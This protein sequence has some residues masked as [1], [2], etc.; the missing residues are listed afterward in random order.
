[1]LCY[2]CKTDK[3]NQSFTP[4]QFNIT[5]PVCRECRR[6]NNQTQ[7][8]EEKRENKL[9]KL[10]HQKTN[11]KDITVSIHSDIK[12]Y[13]ELNDPDI[14]FCSQYINTDKINIDISVPTAI[15]SVMGTGKTKYVQKIIELARKEEKTVCY[16]CPNISTIQDTRQQLRDNG[17]T[18]SGYK[19]CNITDVVLTTVDSID[20]FLDKDI[21]IIDEVYS[22]F[23]ELGLKSGIQKTGILSSG[24]ETRYRK[25]LE[26]RNVFIL[27]RFI[28]PVLR[29][30]DC[31]QLNGDSTKMRDH[32]VIHNTYK[33]TKQILIND[34]KTDK[35]VSEVAL[36]QNNNLLVQSSE[37][38]TIDTF[39]KKLNA[40]GIDNIIKTS[41]TNKELSNFDFNKHQLKL[42]SPV[43]CRGVS[44][45]SNKVWII[46]SG[47]TVGVVGMVQM[48]DRSRDSKVINIK[49]SNG[50]KQENALLDEYSKLV[51]CAVTNRMIKFISF[52]NFIEKN[53]KNV[54]LFLL[55][56]TYNLL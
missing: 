38:R 50:S 17:I 22:V 10:H 47:R 8:P 13:F 53:H 14:T 30:F 51:E 20:K 2:K 11:L 3:D 12:K 26:H 49:V 21:L 6:K 37:K 35:M 52:N 40:R 29:M 41:V 34:F 32:Q 5:N 1:M 18:V 45:N 36:E 15:Q 33:K 7:T 46:D 43:I 27:D 48:T 42:A 24:I 56:E 44:L 25:I 28:G 54:Y 23:E 31:F 55:Q 39:S 4:S 19:E 16:C 9:K